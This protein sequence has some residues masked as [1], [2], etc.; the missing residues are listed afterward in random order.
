MLNF[1]R[2]EVE[3]SANFQTLKDKQLRKVRPI[4]FSLRQNDTLQTKS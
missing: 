1:K 2:L 4:K 3:I